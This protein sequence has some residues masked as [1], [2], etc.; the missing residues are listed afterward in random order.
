MHLRHVLERRA[1]VRV[2]KALEV[3]KVPS[4]QPVSEVALEQ[5][6]AAARAVICADQG[7][8]D[9]NGVILVQKHLVALRIDIECEQAPATPLPGRQ[10]AVEGGE[11]PAEQHLC[12][13]REDDPALVPAIVEPRKMVCV[14]VREEEE[15]DGRRTLV[16][17]AAEVVDFVK[18]TPLAARAPPSAEDRRRHIANEGTK[19]RISRRVLKF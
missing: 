12:F 8:R 4:V 6:H 10:A 9:A 1:H 15:V 14:R 11:S 19:K 2:M 5:E 16:P 3:A 13:G 18:S 17:P 7:D